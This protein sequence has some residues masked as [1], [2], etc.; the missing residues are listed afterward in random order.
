MRLVVGL[1][2]IMFAAMARAEPNAVLYQLQ[3]RCGKYAAEVFAKDYDNGKSKPGENLHFNYQAHYN[4]HFEQVLLPGD[5]D[6]LRQGQH[7]HNVSTI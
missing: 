3:E 4:A 1:A 5:I 2:A 6:V 7:E